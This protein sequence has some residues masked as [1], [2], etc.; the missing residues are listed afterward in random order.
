MPHV[1]AVVT[2]KG[3][4]GKTLIAWNLAYTFHVTGHRVLLLDTDGQGNAFKC[5]VRAQEKGHDGPPVMAVDG[6]TLRRDI[7][8]RAGAYEVVVVDTAARLD[9]AVRPTLLCCDVAVV[10]VLSGKGDEEALVEQTLPV[11]EEARRTRP[12]LVWGVVLN[13]DSATTR[14]EQLRAKLKELRVP[15]LPALGR[16]EAFGRAFDEGLGVLGYAAPGTKPAREMRRL[17]KAVR[18]MLG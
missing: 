9:D 3:G 18:K 14:A 5:G 1:V 16:R 15:L 4:V 13:C 10:P 12:G 17:F 11:L 6:R 2:R 7:D 8:R